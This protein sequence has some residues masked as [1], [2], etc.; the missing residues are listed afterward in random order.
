MSNDISIA[1][2]TMKTIGAV[3]AFAVALGVV[4]AVLLDID[5]T[6][7]DLARPE[8]DAVVIEAERGS[9]RATSITQL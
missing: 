7:L 8:H 4:E 3:L 1:A 6:L 5:G 2:M 9:G